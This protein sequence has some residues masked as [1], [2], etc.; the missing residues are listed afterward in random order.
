M[1]PNN[2]MWLNIAVALLGGIVGGGIS[3]SGILPDD[4]SQQIVK[5]SA[6][7]LSVYGIV[8]ATLHGV[9]TSDK[10]PLVK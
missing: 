3:F 5:Y 1:S 10:G 6:F 2:A 7:T 9:S 4:I 8:N